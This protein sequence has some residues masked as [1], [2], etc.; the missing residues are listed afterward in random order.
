[1]MLQPGDVVS[2]LDPQGEPW[3]IM[4]A[5]ATDTYFIGVDPDGVRR[6]GRT[7]TIVHVRTKEEVLRGE[8]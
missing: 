7:D 4:V 2:Y 3:S 8:G 6:W 1:M 5:Y